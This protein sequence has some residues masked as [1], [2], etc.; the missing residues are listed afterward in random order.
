MGGSAC[1]IVTGS[2]AAADVMAVEIFVRTRVRKL[3]GEAGMAGTGA[4]SSW[5]RMKFGLSA[6][7]APEILVACL[8]VLGVDPDMAEGRQPFVQIFAQ[9][10]HAHEVAG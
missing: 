5:T 9:R 3:V 1:P 8:V 2:A 6:M 7:P 10:G 4:V